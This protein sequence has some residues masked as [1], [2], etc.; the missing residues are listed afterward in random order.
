MGYFFYYQEQTVVGGLKYTTVMEGYS[1]KDYYVGGDAISKRGMLILKRPVQRGMM[2]NWDDMEHIWHDAFYSWLRVAPEEH[3]VLLT[4]VPLNPKPNREKATQ[5]MFETFSTTAFYIANQA[6]MSLVSMG[7]RTGMVIES[8]GGV[9]HCVPVF[10]GCAIPHSTVK[11]EIGGN[12]LND[13]MR[14]LLESE[15]GYSFGTS[16]EQELVRDMKERLCYV[17]IDFQSEVKNATQPQAVD[18]TYTLPDGQEI[19]IGKERFCTPEALF[20]PAMLG[21][22]FTETPGIHQCCV[23]SIAQS[24]TTIQ[25]QLL[26]NIVVSGGNSNFNGIVPRLLRE[27]TSA[28]TVPEETKVRVTAPRDGSLAAWCGGS[29]L[30]SLGT[31]TS[32]CI[33]KEL[34]DECGPEVIHRL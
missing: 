21:T 17:A 2:T 6:V 32:M 31:F 18:V 29:L 22:A 10:D 30:S 1:W 7:H 15:H 19:V 25:R 9:T 23:Q 11:L 3:A 5:I 26:G 8:G 24:D 27:I 20:Q 16:S 12:D 33:T 34:Y 13:H 14:R 28:L 4:D